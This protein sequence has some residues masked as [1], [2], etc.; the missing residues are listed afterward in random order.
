MTTID[1]LIIELSTNNSKPVLVKISRN[2]RKPY[3]VDGGRTPA[4]AAEIIQASIK[5][6]IG[7]R[8]D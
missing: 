2:G 4:T 7:I 8:F 5:A 3:F 1:A 6:R